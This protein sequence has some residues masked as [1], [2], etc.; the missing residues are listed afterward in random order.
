LVALSFVAFVLF[1][2]HYFGTTIRESLNE[3]SETIKSEL[4]NFLTLKQESLQELLKEH[5]KVSHLK[6][7]FGV[8]SSFTQKELLPIGKSS[9]DSCRSVISQQIEQ[10]LQTLASSRSAL[11]QKLQQLMAK[12]ILSLVLVQISRLEKKNKGGYRGPQLH[13]KAIR[14]SIELLKSGQ[15]SK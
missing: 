13:P 11:Q 6:E 3:R 14:N 7:T 4:Q 1:I 10:K 5:H 9:A 2:S 15:R 12:N 8:L